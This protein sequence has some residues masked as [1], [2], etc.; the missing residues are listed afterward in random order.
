M[1]S[2]YRLVDA[3]GSSAMAAS[4]MWSNMPSF[5]ASTAGTPS[6]Q[7][8]TATDDGSAHQQRSNN[9][10]NVQQRSNN[11]GNVLQRSNSGNAH[12]KAP[13]PYNKRATPSGSL[14]KRSA[15]KNAKS[16]PVNDANIPRDL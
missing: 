4:N 7:S 3:G 13:V 2:P 8:S 12:Q 11:S 6:G 15:L 1:F 10:G 14:L 9:S 5:Y 16:G